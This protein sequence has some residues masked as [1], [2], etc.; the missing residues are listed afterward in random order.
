[1]KI[2]ARPGP[3]EMGLLA[4]RLSA[5]ASRLKVFPS[6]PRLLKHCVSLA[7]RFSSIYGLPRGSNRSELFVWPTYKSDV[8]NNF[9]ARADAR[10]LCGEGNQRQ[11]TLGMSSLIAR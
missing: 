1:M 7:C 4:T 8:P 6:S 5:H 2:S 9:F 11:K 3:A 10:G